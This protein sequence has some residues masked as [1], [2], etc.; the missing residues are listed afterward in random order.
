ML[1]C[2]DL[3]PDKDKEEKLKE[4]KNELKE[5]VERLTEK[6]LLEEDDAQKLMSLI[7]E[8]IETKKEPVIKRIIKKICSML[9]YFSIMYVSV[10]ISF[11]LFFNSLALDN[12]WY[13]FIVGL[14]ISLILMLI[15][16][17]PWVG[18]GIMKK[19]F[20]LKYLVVIILFITLICLVNSYLY[21]VFDFSIVWI[22]H[23]IISYIIYTLLEFYLA[24]KFDF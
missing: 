16:C 14:V 19:F 23:I 18:D 4:E 7:D 24:K 5:S 20:L 21:R 1:K 8:V 3:M 10:T 11:G 9:I 22:F 13:V 15:N 6:G 17:L 2:G 12:K